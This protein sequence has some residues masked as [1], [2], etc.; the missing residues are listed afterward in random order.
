MLKRFGIDTRNL[1]AEKLRSDY[2]TLYS[3]KQ[4][5]QNTYKTAE[6]EL[7]GLNRKL[8]NLNQY[9]DWTP[10]PQATGDKKH[11]KSQNSL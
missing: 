5:L 10:A 11:D 8:D 7:A 9:L 1:D 4:T 2:N 6:K 3:K